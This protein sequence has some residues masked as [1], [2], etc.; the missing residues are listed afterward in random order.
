MTKKTLQ[1]LPQDIYGLFDPDVPHIVDEDN[2]EEFCNNLK[3]SLRDALAP[4]YGGEGTLRMSQ[5]GKPDRKV[6]MEY[7]GTEQAKM[8]G[9]TYLKFLYGHLIEELVLFLSKEA[10]HEVRGEQDVM[11]L[12]GIKGHRD[13]V[14]DGVL[15]DVKSASTYAYNSKFTTGN[16]VDDHSFGY[17]T[18]LSAYVEASDDCD[19]SKAAWI[20]FDKQH[21]RICVT[22][23]DKALL[24][25]ASERMEE[26]KEV[27]KG[28][29]PEPCYEPVPDGMSGNMK[30]QVGCGYCNFRK[31]CWPQARTFIYSNGPRYLTTV[32]KL[33]KVPESHE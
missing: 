5:V 26:I 2:L 19:P 23:V 14:V 16:V 3:H 28:P 9:D 10:G 8:S 1:T 17:P 30:L 27:V 31:T 25:N 13:A 29:L 20:A 7:H 33:P 18:Q 4:S 15:C 12:S 32:A 21:G 24:P 6:W 11:H 22:Q